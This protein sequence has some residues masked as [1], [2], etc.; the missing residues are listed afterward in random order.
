MNISSVDS[1]TNFKAKLVIDKR[2]ASKLPGLENLKKIAEGVKSADFIRIRKAPDT[3][4][5]PK[6]DMY[7]V[8][9]EKCAVVQP[10]TS[11]PKQNKHFFGLS[12]KLLDKK[13]AT[14][15]NELLV[16]ESSILEINST[17]MMQDK[18]R[19]IIE[20]K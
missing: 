5:L 8:I 7:V 11:M 17:L 12:T 13:I 15:L 19:S 3:R 1:S 14:L 10:N 4:Y 9:A 2:L 6:Y 20:E 18:Q 16:V